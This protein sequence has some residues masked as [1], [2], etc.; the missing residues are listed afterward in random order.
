M[1][2]FGV[3]IEIK[4]RVQ[5]VGFRPFVWRLAQ[6]YKLRGQIYNNI[7]GVIIELWNSKKTVNK[8]LN[9]LPNELPKLAKFDSITQ[10]RISTDVLP[11]N[12]VI[13]QSLISGNLTTVLPDASICDEC[14]NEI[15]NV[16]DRRYFYPLTNCTL[17]GPR[18]SIM[19]EV[20]YDRIRTSMAPYK[21]CSEC[22]EEFTDPSNRRFHA[23]PI[24]CPKCGP[25]L[26]I[27]IISGKIKIKN[28]FSESNSDDYLFLSSII[29][30][31]EIIALQGIGGFHLICDATKKGIVKKLRQKKKRYEKPLALMAANIEMIRKYCEVSKEEEKWLI[32]PE[33]PILLLKKNKKYSLPEEIAP[34]QDCIGFMLPYTPLHHLLFKNINNPLIMTSGN[35]SNEP[36]CTSIQEV[37]KYLNSI[38]SLAV[39]YKRDIV[40]RLDDSVISNAYGDFQIIRRARGFAPAPIKLPDG[41]SKNST[42][43]AF[44]AD[45]KNTFCL[46]KDGHAIIS[47]HIGDLK[48]F[49]AAEEYEKQINKFLSF[50][51]ADPDAL[52]SDLH[53]DYSSTR[54]GEEMKK[55][56]NILTFPVQHHHAHIASCL[57]ENN[58]PLDHEPIL[59]IALDGMGLGTDNTIWGGE[60]LLSNYRSFERKACFSPIPLLGGNKA[61]IE[62]WR[63]IAA[64][65]M[66][67]FGWDHFFEKYGKLELAS[68]LKEKPLI[69]LNFTKK[70]NP[71]AS[72][73]GRLFD[74][75]SASI[76]ICREKVSFEGQ[77]AMALEAIADKS[78]NEKYNFRWKYDKIL[79]I[80]TLDSKNMWK[81]LF[82]DISNG[83][84]DSLISAKFHNGLA[85]SIIVIVKE[86]YP[87]KNKIKSV[88]KKIALTGGV[89]Q[90]KF[91]TRLVSEKL[92]NE[93][94]QVLKHSKIPANDGGLSFGQALVAIAQLNE[95]KNRVGKRQ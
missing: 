74:A 29:N 48:D 39:W 20:P 38:A 54:H 59:G 33:S 8:F 12:F 60:F 64:H 15:F 89:F 7:S 62:P 28:K 6:K 91:L 5:G 49:R 94:Y 25:K 69:D 65:I 50:Y 55:S 79:K 27:E 80:P 78:V 11:N 51:D 40:N 92:I 22:H 46:V 76:G 4:G 13:N 83:Y 86:I 44:G 21:L 3:R 43:L 17:C 75:V 70:F 82:L 56:L 18:F 81:E 58:I 53:P 72:S 84:R 57:G 93:G 19:S 32:S 1:L 30:S 61:M 9:I 66:I 95:I 73:C 71:P 24:A 41:F 37:R 16:D 67:H 47:Q 87:S 42:I 88:M 23:Q 31:G 85:E 90:N 52:A 34:L 14:V 68:F 2:Y 26:K 77:A 45:L 10:E 36:Q 35:I 63:N